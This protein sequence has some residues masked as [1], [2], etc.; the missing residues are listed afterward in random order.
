MPLDAEER[1]HAAVRQRDLHPWQGCPLRDQGVAAGAQATT[2]AAA[3]RAL[4]RERGAARYARTVSLPG[5]VDATTSR[6]RL[7]NG[8][9]TLSLPKKVGTGATRLSVG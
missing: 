1:L 4:C 5:E 6:A 2:D 8:V 9:L 7:E 3:P